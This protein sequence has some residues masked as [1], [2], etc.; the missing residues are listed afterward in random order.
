MAGI[1]N[2]WFCGLVLMCVALIAAPRVANAEA[3]WND[4]F[5]IYLDGQLLTNPWASTSAYADGVFYPPNTGLISAHLGDGSGG[6]ANS[7]SCRLT[8]Q[9][10]VAYTGTTISFWATYVMNDQNDFVVFEYSTDGWTW[11]V[12]WGPISSTV[13]SGWT[14]YGPFGLPVGAQYIRFRFETDPNGSLSPGGV[15]IDDV[16]FSNPGFPLIVVSDWGDPQPPQGIN[17]IPETANAITCSVTT[18]FNHP[19]QEGVRFICTGWTGDGTIVPVTGTGSSVGV[20]VNGSGWI[21]WNWRRQ[22]G[23]Q[24]ISQDGVGSPATES[25][26]WFDENSSAVITGTKYVAA[27]VAGWGW[28]CSGFAGTGSA[29]ASGVFLATDTIEVRFVI[30]VYSTVTW[31]WLDQYQLTVVNPGGWG[32]PIPATGVSWSDVDASVTASIDALYLEGQTIRH[33]ILGYTLKIGAAPATNGTERVVSFTIS[34]PTTITWNWRTE[35]LLDIRN[36]QFIG[37]VTPDIG[38]YWTTSGTPVTVAAIS[39]AS[40]GVNT[41]LCIGYTYNGAA[42]YFSSYSNPSVSFP[43]TEPVI[44]I[45]IWERETLTFSVFSDFGQPIPGVGDHYYAF[46]SQITASVNSPFYPPSDSGVMYVCTGYTATGSIQPRNSAQLSVTFRIRSQDTTITWNWYTQFKLTI[47]STIPDVVTTPEMRQGGYWYPSGTA[48]AASVES[49]IPG[50]RCT[51]YLMT[52]GSASSSGS[53]TFVSFVIVSPTTI[54]WEWELEPILTNLPSW[55]EPMQISEIDPQLG[56][57]VSMKRDPISGRPS[58]AFYKVDGSRAGSLYFS[59]WDG[60]TWHTEFVDGNQPNGSQAVTTAVNVG[61]YAKLVLDSVGRP[62][63]AYYDST[64]GNLKYALRSVGGGWS[65]TLVDAGGAANGDVGSYC[66]LALNSQNEPRIAYYDATGKDLRVASLK[67][68][69]WTT[70][71]VDTA[72]EVGSHCAISLD[73]VSNMAR[74]A[75]RDDGRHALKFAEQ[76]GDGWTS[77]IIDSSDDTGYTPS[78]VIDRRGNAHIAYQ[79]FNGT[80]SALIYSIQSGDVFYTKTVISGTAPDV[81]FM[82]SL[83]IDAGGHP[84]IA[85]NNSSDHSLIYALY[86]GTAWLTSKLDVGTTGPYISLDLYKNVPAIAYWS[87]TGLRYIEAKSD[88]TTGGT[89]LPDNQT[90]ST[91]TGGGCFIATS[92]FGSYTANAVVDLCDARD[93]VLGA[94]RSGCCIAS[95]YYAVSPSVAESLNSPLGAFMRR[96]LSGLA[97]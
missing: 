44:F 88:S 20:V 32:N 14:Q 8:R 92:A 25:W 91:T 11:T 37:I 40:D 55:N 72:G 41:W 27:P 87:F 10:N 74:I 39:P 85:C 9:V 12:A 7:T 4:G 16:A 93:R 75:Y 61:L 45:W 69:I 42:T 43:M 47:L 36:P 23:A 86:N 28:R 31:L 78:L 82:P 3:S 84:H 67:Q 60:V 81:G 64:N 56:L 89:P 57:S 49:I 65:T 59:Y 70:E 19:L 94:T 73:P 96:A 6:Y 26:F 90:G 13:Q 83:A 17:I 29:P 38:V 35:Y 54:T 1:R 30:S 76:T 79:M 58:V 80:T 51:G 62:H 18:P 46:D 71:I 33:T 97:R 63:I 52:Q 22:Y 5:E 15:W 53:T 95:L 66:S 48:I 68:G 50:Y 34:G 21:Q 24:T 77:W 2:V